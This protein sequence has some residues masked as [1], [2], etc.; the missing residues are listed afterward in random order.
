[1]SS[2]AIA[3]K[4]SKKSY[5]PYTNDGKSTWAATYK[6]NVATDGPTCGLTPVEVTA[7][8]T[9]AQG[10]VDEI[11]NIKDAKAA[12]ES[13]LATA[14]TTLKNHLSV[15]RSGVKRMK[16][17]SG[18]TTGIGQHLQVIG[19]EPSIDIVNSKPVLT[20]SKVPTGYEIKFNLLDFFDGV[21][22]YRRR[23]T[24]ATASYLATDTS[25]PYIDTDPMT[26][27]T[28]YFALFLLDDDEAGKPGDIVKVKL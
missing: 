15:I 5:L 1:M 7:Q 26:D 8:Q 6:T 16:T 9:A 21:H 19:D 28:E 3:N 4:M 25:S 27:G 2:R 17:H 14:K 23:A 18:Y 12:Y 13:A 10:I 20:V 22:I 24:D 11:K